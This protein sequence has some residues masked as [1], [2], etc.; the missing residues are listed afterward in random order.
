MHEAVSTPLLWS[1]SH[2]LALMNEHKK[3]NQEAMARIENRSTLL[4][5]E[6]M[7]ILRRFFKAKYKHATCVSYI[8]IHAHMDDLLSNYSFTF[9]IHM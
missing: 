8:R 7:Y 2:I 3:T 4:F 6:N 1:L 9:S 5:A